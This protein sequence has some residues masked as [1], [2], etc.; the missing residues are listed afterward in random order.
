MNAATVQAPAEWVQSI[1]DLRFPPE[2]DLRLQ[3]LMDRNT[4]G[5]LRPDEKEELAALAALSEELSLIRAKA[6]EILG[7]CPG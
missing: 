5:A 4:E 1:G 2:T 3:S 6:L 7:R